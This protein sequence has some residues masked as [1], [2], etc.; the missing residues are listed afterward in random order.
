MTER[1]NEVK[2]LASS[3]IIATLVAILAVSCGG[4]P[5]N[6]TAEIA[7]PSFTIIEHKNSAL[8][9]GVPDWTTM[10]TGALEA[11]DRF[12]DMYVFKF[13]QSGGDLTG[14]K[15]ISDNMNA[16]SE[17]AR[18]IS[19]RVQ[20]TFAGAQVGDDEF[21]ET[22]FEN[23]V[24]T[25]AQAEINGL[26]KYGDFWVKKQYLTDDGEP[27]EI[28]YTYYTLYTIDQ[29]RIEGLIENAIAGLE[30]TTEEEESARDRVRTLLDE[31]G[32]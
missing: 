13:E 17:V 18:L 31:E 24:K 14:V 5:A 2:K 28:E 11:D 3:I 12:E 21:V 1:R 23:I 16:P 22:Y 27:G 20:Q 6:Q 30:A 25:V 4:G 32:F 7:A 9:G 29:D 10:D 19:T 8:G 26:R 15:T